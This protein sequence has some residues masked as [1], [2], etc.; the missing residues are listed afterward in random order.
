MIVSEIPTWPFASVET[1]TLNGTT[2]TLNFT[3]NK[4]AGDGAG[5]WMLDIADANANP[6]AQ[7]IPLVTGADLLGQL[8]YLGLG[9]AMFVQSDNDPALV[10]SYATL[11]STGHLYWVAA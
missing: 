2:Y 9:G 4:F 10:P 8:E 1:I 7:G 5:C 3:W 6:M 11:G